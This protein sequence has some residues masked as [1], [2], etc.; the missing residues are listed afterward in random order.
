MYACRA[1]LSVGARPQMTSPITTESR[2][3]RRPYSPL[4]LPNTM[5]FVRLA[6]PLR[7]SI[8]RTTYRRL[9]TQPTPQKKSSNNTGLYFLGAGIA[10]IGAYIYLT[11]GP[12]SLKSS[13]STIKPKATNTQSPLDPNAFQNLKLKEVIPYNH[14]TSRSVFVSLSVC[15]YSLS[16]SWYNR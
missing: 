14:N 9:S 6:T 16:E 5:S 2:I 7:A 12:A 8:Q 3:R 10:G 4:S 1:R 15:F 13:T 11:G